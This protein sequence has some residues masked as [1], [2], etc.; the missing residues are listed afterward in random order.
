MGRR[1]RTRPGPG[2]RRGAREGR[3]GNHGA[4]DILLELRK[5]LKA[6][7]VR[8]VDVRLPVRV[9]VQRALI[10]PFEA[11]KDVPLKVVAAFEGAVRP[12]D[13]ALLRGMGITRAGD[14]CEARQSYAG[15]CERA[16]SRVSRLRRE[17]TEPRTS[18]ALLVPL[19]SLTIATRGLG[20]MEKTRRVPTS[21]IRSPLY[22]GAPSWSSSMMRTAR[23][24][25]TAASSGILPS[26]RLDDRESE[27]AR[28]ASERRCCSS[29]ATYGNGVECQQHT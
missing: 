8:D 1:R 4:V 2:T 12:N 9:E 10:R 26:R 6:P 7:R 24:A 17:K 11:G 13:E 21:T 29:S 22:V 27:C 5:E 16:R 19:M 18:R 23:G 25:G 15:V 28:Y 14:L 3:R 20:R